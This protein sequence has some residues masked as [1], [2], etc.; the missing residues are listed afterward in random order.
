M[1]EQ[2]FIKSEEQ[3]GSNTPLFVIDDVLMQN[4]YASASLIMLEL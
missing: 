2:I 4:G 3:E 1:G